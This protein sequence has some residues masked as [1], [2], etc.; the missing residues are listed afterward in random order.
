MS[1]IDQSIPLITWKGFDMAL[2]CR[3]FEYEVGQTYTTDRAVACQE[4]FHGCEIVADLFFYYPPG[5]SRYCRVEQWGEI[6]RDTRDSKIASTA[7][8]LVKEVHISE[9]VEEMVKAVNSAASENSRTATG[10]YSAA[11]ATGDYSAASATGYKSAAST[12]GYQS[13][14]STTGYQS[15][16]MAVG[17]D[18]RAMG[19]DGC[20]IFLTERAENWDILAVWAGIAGR[21]GIKPHT[22]YR[23]VGGKPV[24]VSE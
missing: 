12:T 9:I 17:R 3:G 16:A 18:G 22:W 23:L 13:A 15:A 10:D 1:T 11:S 4:G 7:I 24:E 6:S 2:S 20:A 8:R 19:A 21:D 5:T 14:A